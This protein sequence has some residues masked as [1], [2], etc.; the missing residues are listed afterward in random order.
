MLF[1]EPKPIQDA[2]TNSFLTTPGLLKGPEDTS[3][4]QLVREPEV[5]WA[6]GPSSGR[7]AMKQGLAVQPEAGRGLGRGKTEVFGLSVL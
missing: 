2:V 1:S 4:I 5:A 7:P 6:L 3:Y